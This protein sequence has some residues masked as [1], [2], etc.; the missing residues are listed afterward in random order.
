MWLAYG[1]HCLHRRHAIS[2][3]N[4]EMIGLVSPRDKYEMI[5]ITHDCSNLMLF[6][7]CR[8][9]DAVVDHQVQ[10]DVKTT[11]GPADF[12]PTLEVDKDSLVHELL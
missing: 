10:E 11:Q 1:L 9:F 8:L 6:C 5:D 3:D 2:T 4:L 12:P 7:R